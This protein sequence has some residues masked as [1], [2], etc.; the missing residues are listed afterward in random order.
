MSASTP[1]AP[2]TSTRRRALA[3]FAAIGLAGLVTALGAAPPAHAGT[4]TIWA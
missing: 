4:Y 1:D 3:C 2:P